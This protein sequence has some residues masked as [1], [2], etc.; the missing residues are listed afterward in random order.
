[1]FLLCIPII[2]GEGCIDMPIYLPKMTFC[3]E[4]IFIILFFQITN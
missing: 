3:I 2:H 1:M 4:N